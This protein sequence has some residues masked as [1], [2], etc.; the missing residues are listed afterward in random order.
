MTTKELIEKSQKEADE[1]LRK[2]DVA[3]FG[4]F[5]EY[6]EFILKQCIDINIAKLNRSK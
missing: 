1:I 3:P 2:V 6:R 5:A 4:T